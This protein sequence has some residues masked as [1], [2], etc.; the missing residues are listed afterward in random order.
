MLPTLWNRKT[1]IFS[2][3]FDDLIEGFKSDFNQ[4][5]GGSFDKDEDGNSICELEVP[6]FNKDNLSVELENGILTVKGETENR[7]LM[8]T[9]TVGKVEDIDA[10]IKDRILTITLIEPTGDETKKIELK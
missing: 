7:K 1:D 4:V 9:I 3:T 10:A 6:G 8:K 2:T 5:F